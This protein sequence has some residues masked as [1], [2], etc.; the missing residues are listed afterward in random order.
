MTMIIPWLLVVSIAIVV[1]A[2]SVM[3]MVAVQL[4]NGYNNMINNNNNQNNDTNNNSN[5]T[6]YN[7]LYC[8]AIQLI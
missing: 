8:N 7:V 4:N 1:N 3:T 6:C 2:V 5:V